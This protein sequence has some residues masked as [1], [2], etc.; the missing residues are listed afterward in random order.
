MKRSPIYM[1]KWLDFN[2]RTRIQPS[3]QW[4]LNFTIEILPIIQRSALFSQDEKSVQIEAALTAGIYFQD[5]IAQTGGWRIFADM[6][7]SLYN[8]YLPFY[9]TTDEYVPDEINPEDIAFLLWEIKSHPVFLWNTDFSFYNPFDK[10]LLDLSKELY[11]IMDARFEEAPI[12]QEPSSMIWAMGIDLLEIPSTPLPE[13]TANTRL[14]EDARRCL[15]YSKGEPLLYFDTYR[16]LC[17]FFVD[18]LGWE[19]KPSAWMPELESSKNF[20]IYANAKGMLIAPDV[21]QYFCDA[22]NPAYNAEAAAKDGYRMFCQPGMCPFDL[23]KYGMHK[24]LL[25]DV[26]L[27]FDHGKEL[28]QDNWDFIARYYL[29]E[30]Y[31]G[32]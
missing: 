2:E 20:V 14:T 22:H 32:G 17:S 13:V 6:Y 8:R 3:D 12:S 21:A 31:E 16:K 30:Y 27:P 10:K 1:K 15:E 26:R 23:L 28:L 25:T 29:S 19:N 5:A 11:E 7:Q 18:V 4:Y 9:H 24:G